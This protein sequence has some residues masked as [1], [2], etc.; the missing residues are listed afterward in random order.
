MQCA[1]V[2]I[3]LPN[4][5]FEKNRIIVTTKLNKTAEASPSGFCDEEDQELFKFD[6]RTIDEKHKKRLDTWLEFEHHFQQHHWFIDAVRKDWFS[7]QTASFLHFAS[8]FVQKVTAHYYLKDYCKK[9][10]PA[11][12]T[13]KCALTI[14][15]FK[16]ISEYN[17]MLTSSARAFDPSKH[18]DFSEYI[19][20]M[21]TVDDVYEVDGV[22]YSD[23]QHYEMVKQNEKVEQWNR[24]QEALRIV[25]EAEERQLREQAKKDAEA[26]AKQQEQSQ[27]AEGKPQGGNNDNKKE[28]L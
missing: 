8:P 13:T 2:A 4:T 11:F 6:P 9:E 7:N 19:E 25:H 10:Y 15:S 16:P 3:Q 5:R 12:D 26:T 22:Y 20:A 1:G 28:D 14:S 21:R 18:D 17:K 27:K 23:K 24:E